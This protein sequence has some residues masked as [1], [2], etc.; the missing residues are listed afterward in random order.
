MVWFGTLTP[1]LPPG[2][3]VKNFNNSWKLW[4]LLLFHDLGTDSA[5]SPNRWQNGPSLSLS[6]RMSMLVLTRKLGEKLVIGGSITLTVVEIRGNHVRL[7]VD[8]PRHIRILRGELAGRQN[9]PVHSQQLL[10]P[11]V[12]ERLGEWQHD[13]RSL[14]VNPA[15]P[16]QVT[17]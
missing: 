11:A 4:H 1:R 15:D 16:F 17:S 9:Q 3:K 10:E 14:V 2:G 12:D 7:A 13:I 8:A 6:W 5:I